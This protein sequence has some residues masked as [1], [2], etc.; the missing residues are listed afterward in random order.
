MLKKFQVWLGPKPGITTEI[1][2]EKS[3]TAAKQTG[4]QR[5]LEAK[6]AGFSMMASIFGIATG[7]VV[8]GFATSD[9][10]EE[11]KKYPNVEIL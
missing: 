4:R 5:V 7:M 3:R 2:E 6:L 8:C 1:I 9:L 11:T 10:T